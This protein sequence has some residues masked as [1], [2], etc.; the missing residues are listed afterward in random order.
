MLDVLGLDPVE[1]AAYRKLVAVPSASPAELATQLD[2]EVGVL[3][4][5]LAALSEKGLVARSTAGSGEFVA[6]P[7]MVA[8]GSLVRER[9][10]DINRA[11]SELE[12]LTEQYRGAAARRT[13]TDVI[14]VVTGG[15]AVAQRFAQ[16]Q[17]SARSE[18]LA[19]I[20]TGVAVVS[21]E[22]NTEEDR[23]AERGV[24]FRVVME[25]AALEQPGVY[26]NAEEA[27]SRG[28]QV[29]VTD[30]LPLR[31]ILVDRELALVP[32]APAEEEGRGPVGALLVHPSGLLDG[33]LALFGHA[34]ATGRP[35]GTT[36]TG[37]AARDGLDETDLR[38]L[39]LLLSGLTDQAVGSQLGLSVRT[40]QRRVATLMEACA[41][42]T[43]IQLGLQAH[44]RG[45]VS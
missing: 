12:A 16:L 32:L 29:R 6:S 13:V 42:H 27:M 14:D 35:L 3:G 10:E 40:V 9:Q 36:P 44:K 1:E 33:L 19:L 7:P 24:S 11:R 21:A 38:V 5:A 41:V 30:K 17:R 31:M 28:E 15:E 23:A 45:W 26:R 39:T 8:L 20:R 25:R 43:R 4:P 37:P 22:Q 18:V 34:W 2:I